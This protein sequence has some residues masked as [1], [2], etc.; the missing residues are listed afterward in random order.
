MGL[1]N[2]L[3]ES[4]AVEDSSRYQFTLRQDNTHMYCNKK[5]IKIYVKNLNSFKGMIDFVEYTIQKLQ[6]DGT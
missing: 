3:F 5:K 6:R 1:W 2:I 4:L